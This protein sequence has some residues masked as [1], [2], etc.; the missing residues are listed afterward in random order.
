M[1]N[2]R[3]GFNPEKHCSLGLM[4]KAIESQLI[5]LNEPQLRRLLMALNEQL[6]GVESN[7]LKDLL[8]DTRNQGNQAPSQS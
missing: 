6:A 5:L 3:G 4:R 7:D 8:N 2:N 1:G